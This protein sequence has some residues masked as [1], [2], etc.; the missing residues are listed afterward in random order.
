LRGWREDGSILLL[1][2]ADNLFYIVPKA[3]AGEEVID[4]LRKIIEAGGVPRS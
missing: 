2:V 3:Q 4:G 1:Y